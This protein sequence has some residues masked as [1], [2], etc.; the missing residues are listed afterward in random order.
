MVLDRWHKRLNQ[1]DIGFPTICVQLHLN[2]IVTEAVDRAAAKRHAQILAYM[3]CQL[4]MCV[5]AKDHNIA[6]CE[7]LSREWF[8]VDWASIRLD[9]LTELP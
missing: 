6:H 7:P 9:Q 5:S 2:T 1:K 8:R 3:F 4:T